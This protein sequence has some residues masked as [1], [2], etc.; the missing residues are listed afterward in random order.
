M[1]Q[2]HE[3]FSELKIII[4]RGLLLKLSKVS[5]GLIICASLLVGG[6]AGS[7]GDSIYNRH[8]EEKQE[9]AEVKAKASSDDESKKESSSVSSSSMTDSAESESES[10]EDESTLTS[11]SSIANQGNGQLYDAS[12]KTFAGYHNIHELWNSGYT[13]TGYLIKK[14]GY[15]AD[16]AHEYI[17]Q[18]FDEISPFLGSGE[19]QTYYQNMRSENGEVGANS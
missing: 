6:L 1:G 4:G 18:H 7:Y 11:K 9:Q 14:C 12:N 2:V 3:K 10:I 17:R 19:L 8:N 13:L 16:Q 5:L 15:T